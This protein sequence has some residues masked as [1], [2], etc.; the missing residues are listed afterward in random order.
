MFEALV[1]SH[2]ILIF[3]KKSP[4]EWR[5]RPDMTIYVDCDVQHQLKL[6]LCLHILL[7]LVPGL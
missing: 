4:I 5:Q 3:G 1:R 7:M 2:D 6:V